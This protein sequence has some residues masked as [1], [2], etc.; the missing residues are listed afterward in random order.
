MAEVESLHPRLVERVFQT[1]SQIVGGS[2]GAALGF[3][4]GTGPVGTAVAGAAIAPVITQGVAEFGRRLLGRREE[5]RVGA[6][7]SLIVGRVRERLEAGELPRADGFFQPR[8]IGRPAAEEVFEGVLLKARDAYEEKKLPLFGNLYASI[9]F[10]DSISASNANHLVS[11]AGQLTYRQ[12]VILSLIGEQHL[13]GPLMRESDLH[14]DDEDTK[15]MDATRDT[16]S[17]YQPAGGALR[18][19]GARNPRRSMATRVDSTKS[20]SSRRPAR[21]GRRRWRR[22]RRTCRDGGGA[23]GSAASPPAHPHPAR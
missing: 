8:D 9:A 6:T 14:G 3:L 7:A 4:T 21:C 1:G 2:A 5:A 22:P 11:L 13:D 19:G 23:D 10:D 16:G 15:R 18:V 17:S 20:S 12:F